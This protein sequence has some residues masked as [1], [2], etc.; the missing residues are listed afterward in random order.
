MPV[1]VVQGTAD[2]ILPI[3]VTA[4]RLPGLIA[5]LRLVEIEDGPHNIG[6]THPEEVN[7]A[8]VDFIEDDEPTA[9]G[10]AKAIV[11]A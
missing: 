9:V 11:A 1:L 4:R 3:D 6:W 5:D 2:R 7:R 8:L 10:M